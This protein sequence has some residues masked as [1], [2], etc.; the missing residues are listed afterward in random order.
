MNVTLREILK[1]P[2]VALEFLTILRITRPRIYENS[3]FA[4]SISCY[5]I[6][7]L[8]IGAFLWISAS[9]LERIVEPEINSVI[10]LIILALVSG[11]LHLDGLADTADGLAS[12]GNKADKLGIMSIGNTGPAGVV[13]LILTLLLQWVVLAEILQLDGNLI[14][15]A[16]ILMPMLGRWSVIPMV[17]LFPP[18]R[19]SGLGNSIQQSLITIPMIIG[20]IVAIIASTF[21]LGLTGIL[22]IIVAAATSV[23]V[24][25]FASKQLEGIT[26]DILGAGIEL[27]QTTVLV[28]FLIASGTAFLLA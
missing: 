8:G 16:L 6:I 22:L 26:G 23:T 13:A 5:P 7:G 11:G 3:S 21:M 17:G 4:R 18:A 2:L 12:Q 20:T 27:S 10:L 14:R 25:W 19:L 1:Y 15:S 28:A 24:A 9:L